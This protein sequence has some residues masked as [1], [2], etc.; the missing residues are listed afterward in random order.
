MKYSEVQQYFE[1]IGD[2]LTKVKTTCAS[3]AEFNEVKMNLKGL[4]MVVEDMNWKPE[5]L[6]ENPRKESWI[7]YQL[8][9][10]LK[11]YMDAAEVKTAKDLLQEQADQIVAKLLVDK[12]NLD[13]W[14]KHIDLKSIDFLI[15]SDASN[16]DAIGIRGEVK[17]NDPA[18]FNINTELWNS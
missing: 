3:V 12:K 2:K 13:L 6:A 18:D 17:I 1:D 7:Y 11:S 4:T 8:W 9:V 15:V 5:S 10:P 16:I 14:T